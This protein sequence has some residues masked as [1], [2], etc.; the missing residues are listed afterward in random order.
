MNRIRFIDRNACEYCLAA[1]TALGRQAGVSADETRAARTRE[2]ADAKTNAALRYALKLVNERG[3]VSG[4]DVQALSA[5]SFS[6]EEMVR[7]RT[8][9]A[10]NLFTKYVNVAFAVPLDSP[11]VPLRLAA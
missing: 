4:T 10:L 7:D 5:A 2:S 11:A 9:V 8:H 3:R 6:V 1:H